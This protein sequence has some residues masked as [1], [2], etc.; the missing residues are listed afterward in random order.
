M[1]AIAALPMYDRPELAV[2]HDAMWTL[3]ALALRDR[4]IA[5]PAALSRDIGLWEGWEHPALVLGQ[6]CSLPY[7][8][9]LHDRVTLVATFDYGL[10]G[11]APGQ[12]HSV[13]LVRADDPRGLPAELA[14]ARLAINQPHSQSGWAAACDWLA[15]A[16]LS[17]RPVLETGSHRGS[18]LAVAE[19]RA[20][21]A[22]LD[23]VTWRG[24]A[25]HEPDL[26]ARLRI[27]AGTPP[28]PALPL[29]AA[30]GQ[31]GAAIAAALAEA[32]MA[33]DPA[34]RR[35]LGIDGVVPV[36]PADYLAL[37]IPP[38]A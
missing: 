20:D 38:A 31:D 14:P 28:T 6:T 1:T 29:I 16:G 13:V 25:R 12:Y 24:I 8:T 9:R 4:G 7:R 37:P 18:A 19:A 2:A 33:L 26:A 32:L 3:T 10:P 17:A 5:A 11:L 22:T 15:A 34:H 35:D 27:A 36:R 23:A 30:A 21:W